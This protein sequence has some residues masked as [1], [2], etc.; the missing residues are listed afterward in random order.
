MINKWVNTN[1]GPLVGASE[2]VIS[3]WKGVDGSSSDAAESDYDRACSVID[4]LGV[5]DCGGF[6]VIV[7]GDEPLQSAFVHCNDN[8]V[9]RWVSCKSYEIANKVLL[10]VPVQLPQLQEK[11]SYSQRDNVFKFFDSVFDGAEDR[12]G[13]EFDLSQGD[14]ILTT[15]LYKED[16]QYEFIV[17]RFKEID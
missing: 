11:L 12:E 6:P 15:E 9:V 17:H 4:F 3:N 13:G 8:L 5:V 1:G 10:E 7:F 2:N 16:D 14:Y